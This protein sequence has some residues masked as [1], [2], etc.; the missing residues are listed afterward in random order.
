MADLIAD[1]DTVDLRLQYKI[2]EGDVLTR[3]LQDAIR[4]SINEILATATL[5]RLFNR[6]FGANLKSYLFEPM[7]D[8][9]AYSLKSDLLLAI[10]AL[11][12]RV[13]IDFRNTVVL[14]NEDRNRYDI[15]LFMRIL[16]T[17][18]VFQYETFLNRE[19]I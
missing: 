16:E 8:F 4:E 3:G 18:D 11:E 5:T 17:G 19:E 9:T 1:T 14:A 13:S 2:E 10:G 15:I 12:P 7:S 6:G